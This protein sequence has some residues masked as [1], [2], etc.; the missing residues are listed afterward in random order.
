MF[1]IAIKI[2]RCSQSRKH[3]SLFSLI[4]TLWDFLNMIKHRYSHVVVTGHAYHNRECSNG[5]RLVMMKWELF[6]CTVVCGQKLD[7]G[8]KQ[9]LY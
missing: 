4:S 7:V 5:S 2:T 1:D 3:T 8:P 9:I 6:I